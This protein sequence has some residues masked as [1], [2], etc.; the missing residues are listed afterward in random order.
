MKKMIQ[1]ANTIAC[2][3]AQL[4]YVE[5]VVCLKLN[6]FKRYH[7][8]P[9]IINFYLGHAFPGLGPPW[10]V[11]GGGGGGGGGARPVGGMMYI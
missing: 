1:I 11:G 4:K 10:L 7:G 9:S 8:N 5:K 6:H 2:I 3:S